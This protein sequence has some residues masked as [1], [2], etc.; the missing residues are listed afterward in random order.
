MSFALLVQIIFAWTQCSLKNL[1]IL[2]H[3]CF[4]VH[5]SGEV[6]EFFIDA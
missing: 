5:L 6:S 2:N 3:V 4:L 1:C